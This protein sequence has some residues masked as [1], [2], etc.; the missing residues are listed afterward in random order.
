[1]LK[2]PGR[3]QRANAVDV[4]LTVSRV[5]D[6]AIEVAISTPGRLKTARPAGQADGR[7]A[8]PA[9]KRASTADKKR[10]RDPR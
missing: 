10:S 3:R 5:S 4:R 8:E 9:V 1:M 7:K 6:G 2:V